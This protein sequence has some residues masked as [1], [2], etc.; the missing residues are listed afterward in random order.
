MGTRRCEG[1]TNFI[2]L[3]CDIYSPFKIILMTFPQT[4]WQMNTFNAY[5]L[6]QLTDTN[7]PLQSF[8][9]LLHWPSL[10]WFSSQLTWKY[11]FP[12][13]G[14]SPWKKSGTALLQ[15]ISWQTNWEYLSFH[16]SA[17]TSMPSI[18]TSPRHVCERLTLGSPRKESNT[19]TRSKIKDWMSRIF[20]KKTMYSLITK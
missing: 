6:T 2:W 1:P 4:G 10:K 12:G 20:L 19:I 8:L 13:L 14:F 15:L 5:L 17:Q 11:C 9:T 3:I 18:F 7:L 16:W